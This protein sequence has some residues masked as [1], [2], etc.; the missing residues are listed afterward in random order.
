MTRKK[1]LTVIVCIVA[2]AAILAAIIYA[3]QYAIAYVRHPAVSHDDHVYD[4]NI[5]IDNKTP[6]EYD[7]EIANRNPYL[8]PISNTK[9]AICRKSS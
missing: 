4:S 8:Y 7:S 2:S 9:I 3:V 1:M 5:V 6:Y